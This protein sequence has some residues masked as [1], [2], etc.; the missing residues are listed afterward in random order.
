MPV[1]GAAVE[2]FRG[3]QGLSMQ[4]IVL[5]LD[6]SG[7][8]SRE[9]ARVISVAELREF[10]ANM[11]MQ[12]GFR[13][14]V[15]DCDDDRIIL[16]RPRCEMRRGEAFLKLLPPAV[17]GPNATLMLQHSGPAMGDSWRATMYLLRLERKGGNWEVVE[18]KRLYG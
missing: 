8:E 14:D 12:S 16:D 5:D 18:H 10:A 13:A 6:L 15:L 9:G 4:E 2:W 1:Y 3:F 7:R 17:A 11:G